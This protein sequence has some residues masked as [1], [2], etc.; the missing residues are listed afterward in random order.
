M[1]MMMMSVEQSAERLA[2]ATEVLE[3]TCTSSALSTTNPA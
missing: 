2:K 3:E 1:M